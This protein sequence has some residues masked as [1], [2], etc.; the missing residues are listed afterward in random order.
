MVGTT[1]SHYKITEKLGEGGM[2]VVYK[3]E[4]T[5]LERP[6]AL[7]FLA[8][9]A[10]E[11]PEHKARFVR[12][13]KAAARLDHSNI[14]SVYEI[15]EAEGQTFLAMAY[16]EG[17]T[18]KDKVAERPLKLDQALDIAVQT[19]Q[20]L[21]AAHEKEIVHRDIKSANLMVTPQGQV[22]IMDFGLAQLAERSKL[23]ETSTI[24]GTPSY[25]SPEQAVGEKTDRRTD[26]WSLGAVLY[27]MVTGRLPFEAER[28]EA[29]LFKIG[30]EEPEPVTALR[31]GLP[32]E[33]EWIVG[34]CLAKAPEERYQ[35]A[36]DL[37]VDLR[38]LQK[39]LASGKS[40]LL[41]AGGATGASTSTAQLPG[42]AESLSARVERRQIVVLA[43]GA[44]GVVIGLVFA[45][46]WL[47][48]P[49][50]VAEAPLRRV[51]VSTQGTPHSPSISSDGRQVAYLT[52]TFG[53]A[54]LWVQDL[55]QEQPRSIAGPGPIWFGQ[56]LAWSHDSRF[57]CFRLGDELKKVAASGGPVATLCELTGPT[58]GVTW[59]PDGDSIIVSM[60]TRQG[61]LFQVPAS[62]GEPQ[63]WLKPQQEGL[64]AVDPQFF[65]A[66]DG[67][68]KLLYVER[69]GRDEAQFSAQIFAVDRASERRERLA[70]GERPR[71]ASSGHVIY[72]NRDPPGIWALPFSVET[73]SPT[74]DPFS[75]KDN[76]R[77]PSVSLDGTL[78]YLEGAAELRR[79]QLVWRDRQGNELGTIGQPQ[80]QI[81]YPA[82]SP[83]GKRVA[84]WGNEGAAGDIWI[85]EVARP[86]KQRLTHHQARDLWPTWSPSG[87]RIG[88]SSGRSGGRDLYVKRADGS[89]VVAPLLLSPDG[90]EFLTDWSRDESILLFFREGEKA[91]MYYLRKA[92]YGH[93][94]EV[95]FVTSEFKEFRA[96]FSPDERF[97]AYTSNESGR[98]EVY[99]R[100]F[101]DGGG[102]RQ[103]SLQGGLE[104]HWRADGKE[105][106]YVEGDSLMAVPVTTSPSLTIGVPVT[107][108]S[109]P[110]LGGFTGNYDVTPDGDRF[111]L[112]EPVRDEGD[113]FEPR[114]RIVENWYEE[115][116]DREQD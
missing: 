105:L 52:G 2:G 11:D 25:M 64:Y 94:E 112:V 4:D 31:A 116:R 33:L 43:A 29:V 10:I 95:P 28:Q 21:Q 80:D 81:N 76:A 69:K 86:V 85:H 109:A 72:S 97:V 111:I 99:I 59:A 102:R 100:S 37:L 55:A 114:I 70:A 32:M 30:S 61:Q 74:G 56:N 36:E 60:R 38:S 7:K 14:C 96:V 54:V 91:D 35:H 89:G 9:H 6:V 66:P 12:E 42:Q 107:L 1:I 63:P 13:A 47:F 67:F 113:V 46:L 3:A 48:S 45:F 22:K 5:K 58:L 26:L 15:D 65:S 104:P 19:A 18:V 106:F 77:F 24:L 71:Y 44:L 20:G 39:K 83:D 73:M 40:T 108:F 51:T 103:V 27:E 88:F 110:S 16:L 79:K 75:I 62:G 93:Y 90:G 78:V 53:N 84:V 101:P 50:P 82:L 23:T 98:N 87:D 92:P 17:Q 115:F 57:L 68:D 41:R 34:K 8:A 49:A